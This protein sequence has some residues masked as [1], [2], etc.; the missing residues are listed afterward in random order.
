MIVFHDVLKLL[1]EHGWSSYKLVKEQVFGN[2][3]IQRLR[4]GEPIN[5]T[6]ID[7]ICELCDC[8]PA[9]IMHYEQ[10]N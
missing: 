7:K 9:D 6:T 4:T 3:T 5:T 1:S 10:G 2:R 8:Q